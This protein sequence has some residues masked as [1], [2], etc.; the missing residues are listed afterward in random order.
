MEIEGDFAEAAADAISR[1]RYRPATCNGE[2]V[3]TTIQII[4]NFC[5][6]TRSSSSR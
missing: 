4:V 5:P 3:S 6:G 1:W 2:A